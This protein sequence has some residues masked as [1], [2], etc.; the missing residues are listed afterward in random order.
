MA[1][2][3]EKLYFESIDDTFC[4]TLERRLEDAKIEG[5]DEITL[6]EAITDYDNPDYIWCIHY[7]ECIERNLCRKSECPYYESKSGR[8]ICS[9]RGNL[10]M[11]GEEV[12]F[13][14]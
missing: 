6:V 2:K 12:T 13:K 7:V 10:Y 1:T 4:T 11:H 3:T 5:L 8:G 9:N 14:V